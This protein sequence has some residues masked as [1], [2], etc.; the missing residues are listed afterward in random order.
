MEHTLLLFIKYGGTTK[1]ISLLFPIF[2][3][4][5]VCMYLCEYAVYM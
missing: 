3:I 1:V 4:L 5:Y 2:N